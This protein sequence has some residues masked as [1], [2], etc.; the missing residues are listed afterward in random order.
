MS[1]MN[2]FNKENG[3]DH[4]T[5]HTF[6]VNLSSITFPRALFMLFLALQ[7]TGMVEWS[8]WG[9][10]APLLAESAL[11]LGAFVGFIKKEWKRLYGEEG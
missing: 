5:E 9:V 11:Y 8:W 3:L 4:R 7:L 1:A 10:I 6:T 2:F